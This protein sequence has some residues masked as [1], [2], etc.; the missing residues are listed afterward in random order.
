M[1]MVWA[2]GADPMPC[3]VPTAAVL[4]QVSRPTLF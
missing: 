4:G 2:E 3:A 1:G